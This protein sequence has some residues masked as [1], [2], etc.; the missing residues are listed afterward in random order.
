V[1]GAVTR[2]L[3]NENNNKER[4]MKKWNAIDWVTFILVFIG[5]INWGLIG[6]FHFNLLGVLFGYT[7]AITRIIYAAVGLSSIYMLYATCKCCSSDKSCS[8]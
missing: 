7:N 3:P 5:G 4:E 6:F 2:L 8:S 1:V